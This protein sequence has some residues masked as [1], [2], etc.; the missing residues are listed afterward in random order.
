[1]NLLS[2]KYFYNQLKQ[3]GITMPYVTG[4]GADGLFGFFGGE[5]NEL[6]KEMMKSKQYYKARNIYK[7]IKISFEN[8][9][10]TDK[11]FDLEFESMISD[12]EKNN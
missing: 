12:Y 5:Y 2:E 3:N 10:K 4:M 6:L 9:N 7:A 8:S 11:E 1:M